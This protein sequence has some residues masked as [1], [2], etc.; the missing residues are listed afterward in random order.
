MIESFLNKFAARQRY[1]LMEKEIYLIRH[2][3]TDYNRKGVVQG[4]GINS[5]LNETGIS[6][7]Q[8]FYQGF[9]HTGFDKILTSSLKRTQ[10]TVEPFLE[11]GYKPESFK[12]LDEIDWGIHEG[13]ISGS[14]MSKE[15]STMISEWKAGNLHLKIEGGESPLELQKR[16]IYFIEHHLIPMSYNKLLICCHGRAIRS[17]LCTLLGKN[18]ASMDEFPHRNLSLYKLKQDGDQFKLELFNYTDHVNN[19]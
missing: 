9:R 7:A 15:Y 12:E 4:R 19:M 17:L 11:L 18:L 1:R 10:Q 14:D 8:A 3:E 2:G 5:S 13:K 16:Q 6:Q